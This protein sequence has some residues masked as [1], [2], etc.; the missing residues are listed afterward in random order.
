MTPQFPP[1]YTSDMGGQSANQRPS[2]LLTRT[3]A[4]EVDKLQGRS[5]REKTRLQQQSNL[6][7]SSFRWPPYDTRVTRHLR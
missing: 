3:P 7:R 2:R 4:V 1:G 6:H 5:S